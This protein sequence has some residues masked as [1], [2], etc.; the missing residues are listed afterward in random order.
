MP[1]RTTSEERAALAA[2]MRAYNAT[3]KD[4]EETRRK[5]A[6]GLRRAWAKV[7]PEER[8]RRGEGFRKI[9]A[10]P[11][12]RQRRS[13]QMKRLHAEGK[14]PKVRVGPRLSHWRNPPRPRLRPD[15]LTEDGR[16]KLSE[17]MRLRN[18]MKNPEV[19]A[20]VFATTRQ[21][22]LAGA[23]QAAPF[24][25][26]QGPNKAER[27]V[28][29]LLEP[30][31]FRFVGDGAFWIG[32]CKSGNRR[33]PDFIYRS[34]KNKVG[35][36]YHSTYWHTRNLAA[37]QAEAADYE[38]AGWRMFVIWDAMMVSPEATLAS[39]KDWLVGL[40]FSVSKQQG[41]ARSTT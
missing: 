23:Y 20:R 38:H 16:R 3:R 19:V 22:R 30:S 17:R 4:S 27:I 40:G 9:N 37:E 15:H 35:V 34:G 13:E 33:N 31:G 26:G 18:P 41:Q 11:N 24:T 14:I 29:A 21:R 7:T 25:P 10:D 8:R 36:L 1:R 12:E 39:V 2:R 28:A 6:E 5:R 32:P